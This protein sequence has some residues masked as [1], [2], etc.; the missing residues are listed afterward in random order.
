MTG[1]SRQEYK[2]SSSFTTQLRQ[3]GDVLCTVSQSLWKEGAPVAYSGNLLLGVPC[4]DSPTS[5][6]W[7]PPELTTS[8]PS[9]VFGSA[10]G[11]AQIKTSTHL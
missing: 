8:T 9:L 3:L 1:G 2:Y 11:R 10:S 4:I 5:A 6:A 7:D